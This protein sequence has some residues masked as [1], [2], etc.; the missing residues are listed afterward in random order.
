MCADQKLVDL[1]T[2]WFSLTFSLSFFMGTGN[3]AV[4]THSDP[5]ATNG[6]AGF[7][8]RVWVLRFM[9]VWKIDS[10]DFIV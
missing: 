1:L 3:F 5:L 4:K 7:L 9:H 2:F 6:V 10:F 8:I